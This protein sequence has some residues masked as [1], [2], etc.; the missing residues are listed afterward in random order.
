MWQSYLIH[1]AVEKKAG[2]FKPNV[3]NSFLCGVDPRSLPFPSL[4]QH[5]SGRGKG[6]GR[7][8]REGEN[9]MAAAGVVT[10][11]TEK[12]SSPRMAA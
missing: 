11:A 12:L 3:R 5:A 7:E 4:V 2:G 10:I 9:A 8:E 1:A 6:R